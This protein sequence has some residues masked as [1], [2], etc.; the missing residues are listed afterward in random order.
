MSGYEKTR[1]DPVTGDIILS[2]REIEYNRGTVRFLL[3][4]VPAVAELIEAE[5]D[6][7][8]YLDGTFGSHVVYGDMLTKHMIRLAEADPRDEE[9]I[10]RVSAFL[11]EI[12][13]DEGG[14]DNAAELSVIESVLDNSIPASRLFIRDLGGPHTRR[15]A[16]SCAERFDLPLEGL[17]DPDAPRDAKGRPIRSDPRWQRRPPKH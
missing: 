7:E 13:A 5:S 2:P 4:R 11:E 14:L 1:F 12:S 16:E 15:L 8:P 6:K 17:F 10:A 9:E 3:E